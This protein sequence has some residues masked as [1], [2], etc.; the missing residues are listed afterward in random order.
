MQGEQA[1]SEEEQIGATF[2]LDAAA[3]QRI[4]TR[5][6]RRQAE[7][8]QGGGFAETAQGVIGLRTVGE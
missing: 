4:E 8:A 5:R 7:F 6:R 1:I 2:G 3:R